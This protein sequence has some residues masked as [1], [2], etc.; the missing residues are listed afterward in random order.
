MATAISHAGLLSPARRRYSRIIAMRSCKVLVVQVRAEIHICI[1][2][3][4]RQTISKLKEYL[5]CFRSG[6]HSRPRRFRAESNPQRYGG[7]ADSRNFAVH[8]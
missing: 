3:S 7:T 2:R 8:A 6:D 1:Q 4:G 5:L